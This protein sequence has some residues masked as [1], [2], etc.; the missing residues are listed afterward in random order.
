MSGFRVAAGT[1]ENGKVQ[2]RYRACSGHSL[3]GMFAL[4]DG[5]DGLCY[6]CRADATEKA[7]KAERYNGSKPASKEAVPPPASAAGNAKRMTARQEKKQK[8][9]EELKAAL[10]VD[11]KKRWP[12]AVQEA[13]RQVE[14][15]P[16]TARTYGAELKRENPEFRAAAE[17]RP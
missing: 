17:A 9:A 12:V 7:R 15:A 16:K 11:A 8:F 4:A 2:A 13:G 6:K 1:V 5:K 14:L 3:Q 10:D